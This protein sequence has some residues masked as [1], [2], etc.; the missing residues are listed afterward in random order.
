[1][2]KDIAGAT[3]GAFMLYFDDGSYNGANIYLKLWNEG[4]YYYDGTD[5][6]IGDYS[7]D[8]WYTFTMDIDIPN[9]TY[10]I[11][12]D[13]S[14]LKNDAAFKGSPSSLTRMC[15]GGDTSGISQGYLDNVKISNDV[16]PEPA[17]MSLLGLGLIGFFVRRKKV[18]S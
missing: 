16:V 15:F 11:Y 14:L 5:H 2:K 1:M 9:S 12:R 3:D 13:G 4:I 17:T 18:S 10:D 7:Y 6:K 8:T